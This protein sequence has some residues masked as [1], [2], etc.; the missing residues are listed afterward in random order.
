MEQKVIDV[1]TVCDKCGNAIDE[2]CS[3]L[4]E[5]GARY[6]RQ[7]REGKGTL[8][9][10]SW[11]YPVGHGSPYVFVAT[12]VKYGDHLLFRGYLTPEQAIAATLGRGTCEAD[13]TETWTCECVGE[14]LTVHVMECSEC[15]H[16]YEHVNG[17]YEYCPRC[18]RK[19]KDAEG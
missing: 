10:V 19:R 8:A 11:E 3:M 14:Q 2:L 16:T 15:G 5:R 1:K 18:G 17:D 9:G 4:D 7:E 6:F 13:A 12:V